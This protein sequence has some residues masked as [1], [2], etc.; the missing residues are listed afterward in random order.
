MCGTGWTSDVTAYV[1]GIACVVNQA[2]IIVNDTTTGC[3]V[4]LN[5]TTPAG[6]GGD[7]SVTV[8]SQGNFSPGTLILKLSLYL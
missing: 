7:Q 8:S 5:C 1:N 3:P 2:S 4:L 6:A